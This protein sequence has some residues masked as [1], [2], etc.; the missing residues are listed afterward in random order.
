MKRRLETGTMKAAPGFLPL[1]AALRRLLLPAFS[2]AVLSL[3][4]CITDDMETQKSTLAHLQV[5]VAA[6]DKEL[7]QIREQITAMSKDLNTLTAIRESQSNLLSQTSDYSKELQALRGRFDE[8]KYFMDKTIKDLTAEIELQKARV[9]ALENQLKEAKPRATAESKETVKPAGEGTEKVPGAAKGDDANTASKGPDDA[10]KLYDEAHIAF[11][12][13]KYAD[14]RKMFERF[15]K[16]HPKTSLT[17]NSYFWIGETYYSE[18]KY[19]D[20]ILAYEDF[21]KNYPKHEKAR[22]AM[23]K[24][25][26]SFIEIGDK[27]TGTVILQ[28]VVEKYPGTREAELARKRLKELSPKAPSRSKAKKQ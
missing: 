18:K 6:H 17:S 10:A 27:K 4:G 14:A 2:L 16:E 11:K 15:V 26:Y 3:S 8:N 1:R 28:T 12:E 21:L 7:S 25:G 20:A 23:L 22:G 19:E 9:A 24:Q 5:Q 13:K